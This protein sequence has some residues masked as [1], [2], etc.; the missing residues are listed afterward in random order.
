MIISKTPL[1]VSF[2]GGGSDL[3]AF[4]EKQPG[5]VLSVTVD[6]YVYICLNSSFDDNYRLS[7]SKT[8]NVESIAEIQH[9]LFRECL[10][11]VPHKKNLEISSLADIPGTGTGLGSSSSF[12]VGLL[13][14]LFRNSGN[15]VPKERLA[16]LACEIE[17]E[18]CN[19]TIGK[20]DQYAAAFGGINRFDFLSN[21]EV[22]QR[23]IGLSPS[24][25]ETLNSH[26][27]F[28]YTGRTRSASSILEKQSSNI[29]QEKATNALVDMVH[30]VS[31]FERSLLD[32]SLS[33]LGGLLNENWR[34]KKS[35]SENISD[36][37]LDEIYEV[38][39]S[40]GALGGK[41]LGAGQGG[42]MMFLAPPD[43][44][45]TIIHETR[46]KPF[47]MNLEFAGSTCL[48]V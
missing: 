5:A 21:G 31:A 39:I 8:E 33:D 32:E 13:H 43:R 35:L 28:L 24:F 19:E 46:L 42:F 1:R 9:P 36:G 37:F 17:I 7:Y 26:L 2:V 11:E 4:F 47:V 30:L 18:R 10:K 44:H 48:S 15:A 45:Q 25:T 22:K 40:H 3:P 14:A 38:G 12:T 20:Q 27:L 16:E 41:L 23:S 6:K 29:K 34:L